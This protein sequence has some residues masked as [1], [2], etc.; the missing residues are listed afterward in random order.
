MKYWN[1]QILLDVKNPVPR[2]NRPILKSLLALAN[3]QIRARVLLKL[4][5][6]HWKFS[7]EISC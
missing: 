2:Q 7:K 1:F 6:S 5:K 4:D 3:L